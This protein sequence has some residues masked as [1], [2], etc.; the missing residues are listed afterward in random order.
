MILTDYYSILQIKQTYKEKTNILLYQILV[1]IIQENIKKPYKNNKF[2]VSAQ[3]W[4][5]ELPDG[6]YSTLDMQ[7]YFEYIL[8]KHGKRQLIL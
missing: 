7:D 2:K 6:L 8:K 4:N 1:F 3:T 5:E